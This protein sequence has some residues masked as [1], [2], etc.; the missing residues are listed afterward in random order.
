MRLMRFV[1]YLLIVGVLVAGGA[2]AWASRHAELPPVAAPDP[3]GFDSALIE[4]GGELV[5]IGHCRHCHTRPGGAPFAGGLEIET[6]FGVLYSTNITPHPDAGIGRWSEE[7]LRRAMHEGLDREGRHLY[8]A[9]PYDR[10]TRVRDEDVAAIYAYIMATVTP[11]DEVAPPHE[12]PFPFNIRQTLEGWKL[13][14]LDRTPWAPDPDKDDEWNYGAYLVE[15]L[16]H[17]GT[18]HSPR[19]ALGGERTGAAA[20]SGG[21]SGEWY[22]PPLNTDV[23]APA[24]WTLFSLVDYMLDGWQEHHGIAA[25]PM[26]H[27]VNGLHDYSEDNAF[28]IAA[29]VI[30]LMGGELPE[31]EHDAQLQAALDYANRLEW[32]AADAP[33]LPENPLLRRGA[34]VFEAQ[35][36]RCHEASR[37]T[38][39]LGLSSAL[40]MPTASNTLLV[41]IEGIPSPT[42]ARGR[43]MDARD[44]EIADDG[45]MVALL[46]FLRDRF[47][48]RPPW[49]DLEDLVRRI[50]HDG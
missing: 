28:A 41:V 11:S 8:P 35:C 29:Y 3:S 39:P 33:P 42:G 34:E 7:A 25:G 30:D 44:R 16:A 37:A 17:C 48:E 50:R 6:P 10:L 38:V 20:Y 31:A 24:P 15:G 4:R 19:N 36:A 27:V 26:M 14:H 46:A 23:Q 18:C 47:T 5:A 45:D 40:N 13:L 49:E 12:L 1:A 9:F 22:A 21:F 2:F 43:S 32:G